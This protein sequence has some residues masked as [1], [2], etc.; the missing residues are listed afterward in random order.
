M[1]TSSNRFAGLA[2]KLLQQ[3]FLYPRKLYR[4]FK[5]LYSILEAFELNRKPGITFPAIL[6]RISST[7]CGVVK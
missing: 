7:F 3:A 6:V 1:G 4:T 2:N 5:V